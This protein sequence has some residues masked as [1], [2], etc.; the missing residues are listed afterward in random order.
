[1]NKARN[2]LIELLHKKSKKIEG[3]NV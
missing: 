2:S 3:E 1:M